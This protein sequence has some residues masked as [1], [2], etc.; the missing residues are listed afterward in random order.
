MNDR[1]DQ[2]SLVSD[3]WRMVEFDS[4][5]QNPSGEGFESEAEW[6]YF[7]RKDQSTWSESKRGGYWKKNEAEIKGRGQIRGSEDNFG[8]GGG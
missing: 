1:G 5:E 6:D 8:G 7:G 4:K 3:R 2:D